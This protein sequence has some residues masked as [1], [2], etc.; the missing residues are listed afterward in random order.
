M[1]DLNLAQVQQLAGDSGYLRTHLDLGLDSSGGPPIYHLAS[2][3][4]VLSV[5]LCDG[6]PAYSRILDPMQELYPHI[7]RVSI[8]PTGAGKTRAERVGQRVI[9]DALPDAML[10]ND[11]SREGFYDCLSLRPA[12]LLAV[13]EFKGLQERLGRDYNA[14]AREFLTEAFDSPPLIRRRTKAGEVEIRSPRINLTTGTTREWFEAAV[15]SG[16]FEGG[17]LSR[18]CYISA[19]EIAPLHRPVIHDWKA[20]WDSMVI[21]IKTVAKLSGPAS[22]QGLE[23]EAWPYMENTHH[24]LGQVEPSVRGFWARINVHVVKLAMLF[25]ASDCPQDLEIRSA[26]WAKAVCL[27][28]HMASTVKHLTAEVA[29][30]RTGKELNKLRRLIVGHPAG[31]DRRTLLRYSHMQ[32]KDFEN[33]LGTLEQIGDAHRHSFSNTQGP[34]TVLVFAGGTCPKCSRNG[35]EHHEH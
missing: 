24:Q 35:S 2:A 15:K 12:G 10:P 30:D 7:Y 3:L 27:M 6:D 18:F 29:F 1:L 20:I 4:S 11:F 28:D 31:V 26:D 22:F 16:D 19:N 5:A 32:A 8:G 9:R 17:W 14:G 21:H 23:A 13:D 25:H 33:H 34:A